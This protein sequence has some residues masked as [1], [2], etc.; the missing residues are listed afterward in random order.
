MIE[1]NHPDFPATGLA[2]SCYVLGDYL[3]TVERRQL[4]K[5]RGK[6]Q[7]DLAK[8]FEEWI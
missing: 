2:K 5:R 7:G 3:G 6:L 8:A 1:A 4:L